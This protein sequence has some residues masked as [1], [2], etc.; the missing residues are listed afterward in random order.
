MQV[1]LEAPE[2]DL[3]RPRRQLVGSTKVTLDAGETCDV[4]VD[5]DPRALEVWD[6]AVAAFRTLPGTH[7]LH[8]GRS[9]RDLR[10]SVAVER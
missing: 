5:V 9:S 6:P 1:Y 7:L 8:V 2:G 3:V 10:G 4:A